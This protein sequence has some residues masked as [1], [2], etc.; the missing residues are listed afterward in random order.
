MNTFKIIN[1]WVFK[2]AFVNH[3]LR[4]LASQKPKRKSRGL[5]DLRIGSL[6]IHLR[7]SSDTSASG[8][9]SIIIAM[10]ISG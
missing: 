9:Y 8:G 2:V 6:D 3:I 1:L 4:A 10:E 7:H 5:E